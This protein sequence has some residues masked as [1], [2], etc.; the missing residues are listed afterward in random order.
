MKYGIYSL[1]GTLAE[2]FPEFMVARAERLVQIYVGV[3]KAEVHMFSCTCLLCP[4]LHKC[5]PPFLLVYLGYKARNVQVALSL[6][7]ACY[8]AVVKLISGCVH[9]ACSGL[10]IR[11]QMQIVNCQVNANCQQA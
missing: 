3:L 7:P 11:S 2:F 10:M 6:L 9:I 1:L 4:S 8:L 5:I